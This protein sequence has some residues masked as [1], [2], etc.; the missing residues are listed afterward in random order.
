MITENSSKLSIAE[1]PNLQRDYFEKRNIAS[2][3]IDS[4]FKNRDKGIILLEESGGKEFAAYSSVL[5]EALK[6]LGGLQRKGIKKGEPVLLALRGSRDFITT[7]WACILGGIIPVPLAPPSSV[8]ARN[9]HMDKICAVW[10]LTGRAGII[11]D[12]FLAEKCDELQGLYNEKGMEMFDVKTL[13][14]GSAGNIDLAEAEL[15]AVIQFSSGSTS[16]PKGVILKHENLLA[17]T[18][19][20]IRAVGLTGNEDENVLSWMP[21]HHNMGLIGFLLVSTALGCNFYVMTPESFIKRPLLWLENMSRYK[22][23]MTASPNFGYRM[24]LRELARKDVRKPDLS[25]VKI[26][27]NGAEPVSAELMSEFSEKLSEFGLSKTAVQPVYGMA[28]AC[29]AVS[30][31]HFEDMAKVHKLNRHKLA[32]KMKACLEDDTHKAVAFADEGYPIPGISIRIVGADGNIVPENSVGEIQIKGPSITSGYFNAPEKSAGLFTEEWLKTGDL[33]YMS[34]GR[35]IVTG[36]IKDIIFINGQN[37]YAHDIENKLEGFT[38]T[39]NG[40]I[41]VCGVHDHRDG[42]EKVVLFSDLKHDCEDP[43][44][45]Y[46]D[47]VQ[48]IND[49][50]G[51]VLDYVVRLPSIPKTASGKIQRF[52]MVEGFLEGKYNDAII[53][54][55]KPGTEIKSSAETPSGSTKKENVSE[56]AAKNFLN[57]SLVFNNSYAETIRDVWSE[58]LEKPAEEIA[59]TVP[60]TSIGGTSVKAFQMLVMLEEKLGMELTHD[61]LINCR[62]IND[63][64]EYLH[65]KMAC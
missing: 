39:E 13:E 30:F 29:L 45:Y 17:H 44:G 63:M 10:K 32:S 51:I 9:D 41:A 28:E 21:F 60:F 56:T 42:S 33:G 22:I 40:R 55:A 27:F 12:S 53:Y 36:R 20:V 1:G 64:D 46:S 52:K 61:I 18:A 25:P 7:F 47:I 65:K 38:Q 4:A 23:T 48:F 24:V 15:P 3:L 50:M 2:F 58:V 26:I 5:E 6:K 43:A 54:K 59:Y 49:E 8:K 37:Y 19:A 16:V 62:T 35:L 34:E 11:T 14:S 31:P 57:N